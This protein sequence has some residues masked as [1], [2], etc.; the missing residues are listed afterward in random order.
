MCFIKNFNIIKFMFK[1]YNKFLICLL[2]IHFSYSQEQLSIPVDTI[3]NENVNN[4]FFDLSIEELLGVDVVDRRFKFYGYI[5]TYAEKTF[6]VAGLDSNSNTIH[7]DVPFEWTPV[8]NFHIYGSGNINDKID[9][10]FNIAR[11]STDGLE[12]RNAWGNFKLKKHLQARIGKMYRRFGLYNEKLDQVPT[13]I[14]I[15]TPELLDVDHL[16]ITRTT[17]FMLHGSYNK[18]VHEFLYAFTTE[19][20]EGGAKSN[21]IPLGWDFRYKNS[22][23]IVGTSGFM[24]SINM[25]NRASSTV[26]FGSGS[27]RGGILPWMSED[28]YAVYGGFVE[29]NIGKLLI[30]SEFWVSPHKGK[31]NSAN[32][33]TLVKNGDLNKNQRERFLGANASKSNAALTTSDVIEDVSY[34]SSTWYVRLGYNIDSKYGQ[35]VPYLFLDWMSNPEIV[36]MKKYGGD[37]ESGYADDGKFLKP[38]VGVVYRPINTVAI[39]FDGSVHSQKFNGK[40]EIY[41]EIRMDFS[42]AFKQWLE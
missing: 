24:S 6:G 42:F 17:N 33:L 8:K 9:V 1:N 38:S 14:G 32:V 11:T 25:K 28:Q 40:N 34:T 10:L 37:E 5:D 21:V 19:N 27:S 36:N 2:G 15:E 39:K 29:K 41:P 18:G 35:F 16:F 12:V 30:Q 23:L 26:S 7:E 3:K 22:S 31:R 4:N 20:G 13:F